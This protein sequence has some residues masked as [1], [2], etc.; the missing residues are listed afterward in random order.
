MPQNL[1]QQFRV[2]SR[3]LR[4]RQRKQQMLKGG[5][6]T[7][8]A[9]IFIG[10]I[11]FL[12]QSD[13]I[14]QLGVISI[15]TI[16]L[17]NLLGFLLLVGL[18]FL[19]VRTSSTPML[20]LKGSFK[21]QYLV[22]FFLLGIALVFQ[23]EPRMITNPIN[24][25]ITQ[26]MHHPQPPA[27]RSPWPWPATVHPS[28]A[29]IPAQ[30]ETSIDSV[31]KYIMKEESDPTLRLK[32]AHD[33]VLKRLTYDKNVLT[34]GNRPPQDAQTVFRTGDAVCEGYAKLFQALGQAMGAEVV[35]VRGDVRR[36]FAP[37]DIIP[38]QLRLKDLDYNWT[39]HAWNAVKVNGNWQL[40]D[41]TWDDSDRNNDYQADYLMLPPV[42]MISSHFPDLSSWQLLEK[43]MSHRDFEGSPILSPQFF[44]EQL[45]LI[46]PTQYQT[47]TQQAASIQI[48]QPSNYANFIVADFEQVKQNE[49][50]FWD[51][52]PTKKSSSSE[53][54]PCQ[55]QVKG[56]STTL[57]CSF[58]APGTYQVF[59]FSQ[60]QQSHPL[61]QLKFE[62]S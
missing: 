38:T 32:A 18:V 36:D 60:G 4:E 28:I 34:T 12:R 52:L 59:M 27:V 24:G 43:P 26:L 46:S 51:V 57:S 23:W 61:G 29:A 17:A 54:S 6:I 53:I 5:A 14:L 35:Y 15:S 42:A 3:K 30:V 7:F 16:D 21:P 2:A 47:K 44:A 10:V 45:A 20:S 13:A 39:Y 19:A 25:T 31:A 22:G 41:T 33:Y 49:S 11:V 8:V 50:S 37:T 56:Q 48:Q 62:V 9:A 40:V 55:S 1:E 58:P